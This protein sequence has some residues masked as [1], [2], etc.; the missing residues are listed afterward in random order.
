M[1]KS[2]GRDE[3][4]KITSALDEALERACA[5]LEFAFPEGVGAGVRAILMGSIQGAAL[6]GEQS[7][8]RLSDWALGE[9]P[10]LPAARSTAHYH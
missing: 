6:K 1:T 9:L 5:A 8:G 7:P 4:P 2:A 10:A 3:L